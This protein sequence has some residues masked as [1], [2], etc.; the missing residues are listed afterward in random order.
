MDY[1]KYKE[2]LKD[3]V[4]EQL[5]E[6]VSVYY[7]EIVKNNNVKKEALVLQTK[8][9]KTRPI[10]YIDSLLKTYACTGNIEESKNTVLEIYKRRD[11][12]LAD[13]NG[14]GWEQ[15]KPYVRI[16][17]VRMEGNEEYLKDRPYK[18]VLDLAI[19]FV[20]LLNEKEGEIAAQV[21][22]TQTETWG[23]DTEELYRTAMDNLRKEEF[24]ITDMTS[25]FPA[26]LV[27]VMPMG[28]DVYIFSTKNRI[29]GARA[30]LRVGMLKKFADEKRCNLF[31][32]PSSVHEVLLICDE[33]GICVEGLKAIVRD[34]NSNSDVIEEEEVLSDSVYY[35]DRGEGEIRIAGE[36][37]LLE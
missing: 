30:M 5:G 23:I 17:L 1:K 29:Q 6:N 11:D 28:I 26:E 15:V 35:Y 33:K 31:I 14:F 20:V 9:E 13:W 7:T 22:W 2:S 12:V 36:G 16:R 3:K 18:K 24:S 21:S 8:G 27:E 10:I 19:I 37:D 4:Q 25:L 32:L 34:I